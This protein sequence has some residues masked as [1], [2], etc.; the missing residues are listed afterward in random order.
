[1]PI[2]PDHEVELLEALAETKSAAECFMAAYD[3][4]DDTVDAVLKSIFHKD[5]YAVKYVVEPLLTTDG[6]LGDILI[7][8]KLL[9]GLGVLSKQVYDDID[10]FVTLKE[11]TKVQ[12]GKVSF[13]E[14]DVI[15]ELN[16]VS[17]I[18]TLMP[19]EFD[20]EFADSLSG[21]SLK[22]YLD[23]YNQKVKSTIELAITGTIHTLCR[24]NSLTS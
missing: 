20:N 19:I 18:K 7:R 16:K 22:M 15:F 17:A 5:D 9:L 6:P 12:E 8:T 11:W 14:P 3:A 21:S 1:M 13:T 4:L 10:I 2:H 23:R 24:D